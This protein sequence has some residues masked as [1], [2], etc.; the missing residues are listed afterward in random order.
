[1]SDDFSSSTGGTVMQPT[2]SATEFNLSQSDEDLIT[3]IR[4]ATD[5]DG[6]VPQSLAELSV[7]TSRQLDHSRVILNKSDQSYQ[8]SMYDE[9]LD[10][11]N[12]NYIQQVFLNG[13]PIDI[14]SNGLELEDVAVYVYLTDNTQY[15]VSIWT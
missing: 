12:R 8:L 11:Y 10:A 13:V 4:R 2:C 1:M 15:V 5:T 3:D 14:H 9:T 6:E 7:K